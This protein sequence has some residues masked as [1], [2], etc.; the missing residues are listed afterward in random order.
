MN[1]LDLALA[2]FLGNAVTL[3]F[4]WSC[5]QFYRHDYKAPW[6][7]YAAFLM[8]VLAVIGALLVTEGLPPQFDALAL[9]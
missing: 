3:A 9:Q 4:A 1:F 6:L 2:V 5:S 8:P 7:A